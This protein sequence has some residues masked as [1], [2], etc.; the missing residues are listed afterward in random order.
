MM[1]SLRISLLGNVSFQ[2]NDK[3]LAGL[4]AIKAQALLIYL[5]VTGRPHT[6]TALAGLL[7]SDVLETAA[8]NSLRVTLAQLRQPLGDFI[9]ATRQT[10]ALARDPSIWLDVTEFVQAC[11]RLQGADASLAESELQ[12]LRAGVHLYRGD[13]VSGFYIPDAER[14]EEWVMAER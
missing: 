9:D 8:Q 6:R 2:L 13:F 3:P 7:W 14:F 11:G 1:P 10:I 4:T 5:A 12:T